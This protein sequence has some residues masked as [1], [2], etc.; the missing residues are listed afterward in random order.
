MTSSWRF[1][2]SRAS[3]LGQRSRDLG[4]KRGNIAGVFKHV[5]G[6]SGLFGV[7]NLVSKPETGIGFGGFAAGSAAAQMRADVAGDL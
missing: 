4:A 3:S 2:C 7:G 6:T 5:I 1:S